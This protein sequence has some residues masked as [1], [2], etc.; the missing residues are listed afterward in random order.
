M[1]IIFLFFITD[2]I[3]TFIGIQSHII[4]EANPLMIWLFT[5]NFA[6]GLLIRFVLAFLLLIPFY[7]CKNKNFIFYRRAVAVVLIIYFPVLLLH[8]RWIIY[9]M[10][11]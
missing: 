7:I 3:L 8:A 10:T 5:C 2:Y 1:P 4:Y 9:L 6:Q 11:S